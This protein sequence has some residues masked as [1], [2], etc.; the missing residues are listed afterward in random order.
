MYWSPTAEAYVTPVG[1]GLVGVAVLSSDRAPFDEQLGRFPDLADR[2]D[3]AKSGPVRGAGPLRRRTSTRVDG[4]VL[5]VGDAAGYVDA[6]TGEGIAVTSS[7]L[8][9]SGRPALRRRLVPA[10]QRVPWAFGAVV[11]QLAR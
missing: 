7:L 8:W 4:R 6:L 5:L 10:A 1:P 3:G 9:V 11:G 2:L